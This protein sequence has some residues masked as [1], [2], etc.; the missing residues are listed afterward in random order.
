MFIK[1]YILVFVIVENIL[2]DYDFI[3]I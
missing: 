3:H 1:M 2:V